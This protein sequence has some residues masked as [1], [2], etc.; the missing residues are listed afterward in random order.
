LRINKKMS[1]P[2]R[3]PEKVDN[4]RGRHRAMRNEKP[5]EIEVR[6]SICQRGSV[7]RSNIY[8]FRCRGQQ[9][10]LNV[11]RN[12]EHLQRSQAHRRKII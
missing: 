9:L 4:W 3:N 5:I 12:N 7:I 6:F 1:Y 10:Q 2:D 8:I 11:I